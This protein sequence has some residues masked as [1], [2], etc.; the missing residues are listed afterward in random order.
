MKI[1]SIEGETRGRRD[2]R[3]KRPEEGETDTSCRELDV[4]GFS[5]FFFFKVKNH[6]WLGLDFVHVR[7]ISTLHSVKHW[8]V[9]SFFFFGTNV[10]VDV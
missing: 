8:E 9:L 2:A 4:T 10:S 6:V 1:E 7:D 5:F 3:K